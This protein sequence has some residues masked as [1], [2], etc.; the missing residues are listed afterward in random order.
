MGIKGRFLKAECIVLAATVMLSPLAL[1][2][3]NEKNEPEVSEE[4]VV[5]ETQFIPTPFPAPSGEYSSDQAAEAEAL[6]RAEKAGLFKE[7]LRGKYAFFLNYYDAVVL[8][9]D[10]T[11]FRAYLFRFFPV[12][13]DHIKPENEVFFLSKLGT[14]SM[15]YVPT[16]E[17]AGGFFSNEI[18]LDEDMKNWKS[19]YLTLVIYHETMHFVDAWIDGEVGEVYYMKDGT[20]KFCDYTEQSN[21]NFDDVVYHSAMGYFT[22]GGAEKYKTEYF[23]RASTDPTPTGLEFLVGL[24]YI[25]GKETVDDMYFSRDTAYKFCNLLKDN[26]F[27]DEEII[28]MLRTSITDEVMKDGSLYIDPR[29]VLIRLYK[30]KIGPDYE[31]DAEFC[32]IIASMNKDLINQIPTEYRDFITKVS[33]MSDKEWNDT[34]KAIKEKT[35]AKSDV[36]FAEEPYTFFIDGKLKLITM[37]STFENSFVYY[38][39]TVIDYDFDKKTVNSFELYDGWKTKE[40]NIGDDEIVNVLKLRSGDNSAAHNQ[41]VKGSNPDT[42]E[43]YKRAETIGN[44]Y[45]IYIWFD[46]LTPEVAL[47]ATF[48]KNP[49]RNPKLIG[50]VLDQIEPVLELYPEGF[51]DQLLFGGFNGV[52]ICIHDS[53]SPNMNNIDTVNINGLNYKVFYVAMKYDRSVNAFQKRLGEYSVRNKFPGVTPIQSRFICDIWAAIERY[54]DICNACHKEPLVSDKDWMAYNYEGF[55][56]PYLLEADQV[57]DYLG[58]ENVNLDY[59]ICQEAIADAATDRFVTYQYLM[60]SSLTGEKPDNMTA[61]QKAKAQELSNGLRKVFDTAKWPAQTAWEKAI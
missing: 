2:G 59:F 21:L 44:K 37:S 43:L 49:A 12:V 50:E 19:D 48:E 29:E 20:F 30:T 3:C 45:G 5:T 52:A 25:F 35:G 13:A 55:T 31:N 58:K 10:V 15:Y 1:C 27:S 38:Y 9:K 39:P 23:T 28:R 54:I 22:E 16:T 18:A 26:G 61:E 14:L 32:R 8:N 7:D 33:K 40:I 42:E 57:V 47:E 51:F 53:T 41:T 46:D 17:F 6:R 60:L 36:V 11:E 4:P 56:Y 24:E 34:L